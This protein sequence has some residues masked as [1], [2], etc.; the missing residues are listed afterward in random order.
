[1]IENISI[2]LERG[3]EAREEATVLLEKNLAKG[4]LSRAYYCIFYYIKAL[5]FRWD[6]ILKPMKAQSTFST[7]I[8]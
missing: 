2:E 4:A 3:E 8:S 5:L 6:L 1:M 7:F